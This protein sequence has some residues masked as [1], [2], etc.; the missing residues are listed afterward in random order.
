MS[1][2]ERLVVS[3]VL[4]AA[5]VEIAER[6]GKVASTNGPIARCP[7]QSGVFELVEY[8]SLEGAKTLEQEELDPQIP[9]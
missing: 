2:V 7:A 5:N 4:H 9:I 3:E 1:P 8:L 6:L